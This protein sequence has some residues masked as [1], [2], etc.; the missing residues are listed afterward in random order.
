MSVFTLGKHTRLELDPLHERSRSGC[1]STLVGGSAPRTP[2]E[3]LRVAS[4]RAGRSAQAAGRCPPPT[5]RPGGDGPGRRGRAR[6]WEV[7]RNPCPAPETTAAA[8]TGDRHGL[9]RR[10]DSAVPSGP[11]GRLVRAPRE[12]TAEARA[13]TRLPRAEAA[14]AAGRPHRHWTAGRSRSQHLRASLA[15]VP[16]PPGS[17]RGRS[18]GGERP[19]APPGGCTPAPA[20]APAG[21][22][23]AGVTT[24]LRAAGLPQGGTGGPIYWRDRP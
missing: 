18:R 21:A 15:W 23:A 19:C 5:P 20:A 8:R 13:G 4:C 24:D 12:Q 17:S 6:P 11:E 10:P 1:V 2:E 16:A 3:A 9:T 14:A 7:G 22:P